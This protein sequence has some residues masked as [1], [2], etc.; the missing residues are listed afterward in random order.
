MRTTVT[1]DSDVWAQLK[2][3]ARESNVSFE[4][5]LNS[6]LRAGL[7]MEA[8]IA[9]RFKVNAKPL[10]ARP[11]VDLNRALRLAD[12]LEEEAFTHK[13]ELKK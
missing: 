1:L 2:E 6:T 10:G 3:V 11:G 4:E 8:S 5:A 12:Q 13:R 7:G 9:T